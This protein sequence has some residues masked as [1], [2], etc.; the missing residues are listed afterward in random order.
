M[1][2]WK[3]EN[4]AAYV[5]ELSEEINHPWDQTGSDLGLT[6]EL[7]LDQPIGASL[8]IVSTPLKQ[9]MSAHLFSFVLPGIEP[10]ASH[11][12]SSLGKFSNTELYPHI[13]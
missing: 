12:L 13:L 6:Q 2:L 8:T 10:K 7:K 5:G 9:T 11:R 4:V 1:V 3:C